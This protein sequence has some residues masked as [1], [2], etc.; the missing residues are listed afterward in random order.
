MV[1][2]NAQFFSETLLIGMDYALSSVN[3]LREGGEQ[4]GLLAGY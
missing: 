4:G 3:V 2:L 1:T